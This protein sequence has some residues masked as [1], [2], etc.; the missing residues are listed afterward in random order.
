MLNDPR[1]TAELDSIIPKIVHGGYYQSGQSCISVQRLLVR[2]VRVSE[3]ES[4]Y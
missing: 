3:S 4:D 2:Q 1:S